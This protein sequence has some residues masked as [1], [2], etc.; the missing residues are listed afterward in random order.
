M[1]ASSAIS[2]RYAK[3]IVESARNAEQ[4]DQFANELLAFCKACERSEDL[5]RVLNNPTF[6]LKDRASTLE[7]VFTKL[8]TANVIQRFI[9]L[10]V[11]RR[12]IN[13]ISGITAAVREIA[14]ARAKRVRAQVESASPLSDDTRD[15]L[16]RALEKRTGKAVQLDI[17]INPNLIGGIRTSLG[18]LV[19][20]GTLLSQINGLRES[21]QAQS[22]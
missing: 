22:E 17:S 10:L 7:A 21:L 8:Q 14:D 11:K 3:A 15:S 6:S 18:S 19:F 9:R 5:I 20:D 16:R 2:R 12:R 4:I 13:E 1:S